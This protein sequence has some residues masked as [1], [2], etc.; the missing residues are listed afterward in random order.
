MY[1]G[2]VAYICM[3][4]VL[5]ADVVDGGCAARAFLHNWVHSE[6]FYN[7]L[8]SNILNKILHISVQ[9]HLNYFNPSISSEKEEIRT[10]KCGNELRV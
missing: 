1:C 6:V 5:V 2:W 7:F 9:F 8:L 3:S 10:N 4:V